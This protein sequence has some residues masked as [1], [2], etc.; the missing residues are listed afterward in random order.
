MHQKTHACQLTTPYVR[1]TSERRYPECAAHV[2]KRVKVTKRWWTC[3]G[4]AYHFSTVGVAYPAHACR[5]CKDPGVRF[6]R[7]SMYKGGPKE[8]H[9][10]GENVVASGDKLLVRGVEHPFSL[11]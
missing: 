5:K 6:V 7:S 9:A 8:Q 3:S 2:L 10:P 1:R 4:C 11:R